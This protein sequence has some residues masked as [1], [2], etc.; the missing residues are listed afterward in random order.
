MAVVTSTD[1]PKSVRI[2][3]VIQIFGGI[4]VLLIGCCIFHWYRGFRHRIRSDL[5]L[6]LSWKAC[7]LKSGKVD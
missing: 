5:V 3:C 7:Q 4:F 1:R 2:L 6:F